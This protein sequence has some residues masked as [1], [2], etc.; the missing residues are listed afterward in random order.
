MIDN[1]CVFGN[2]IE[3]SRSPLIHQQ[4]ALQTEQ[5]INY[6]KKLVPLDQFTHAVDEFIKQGGK[7]ANVTVPFKEQALL[8]CDQLSKAAEKAGAVNTLTFIDGK[9]FGDNTDG[10][11]L[12]SDLLNNKIT[13]TGKKILLLGAGGAAK[14]VV[15]P[16]LTQKPLQLIIANRTI[17][18]AEQIVTQYQ[19]DNLLAL[20]YQALP[21]QAFDLIINATS[22]SLS[23]FVPAIPSNAIAK[24][25]VC[26]DMVYGKQPTSFMVWAKEQGAAIVIDGLGML[27]NQA[28]ES[29]TLWR[30]VKPETTMVLQQLRQA[31]NKE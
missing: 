8:L 25:T 10:L 23:G 13:L 16:L 17:A 27:V 2:P 9:V 26:Y 18:K 31:L 29:F 4:F 3:Q 19:A 14:G 30:K 28:A 21:D 22:A 20:S 24:T 11:G 6:Q 7:G 12:V 1:Y 15:L 5:A